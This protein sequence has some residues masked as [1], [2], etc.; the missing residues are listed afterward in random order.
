MALLALWVGLGMV[1][2]LLTSEA[3]SWPR[4]MLASPAAL[5]FPGIA[6]SALLQH[7]RQCKV[8]LCVDL[9]LCKAGRV[10]LVALLAISKGFV[11]VLPII[12]VAVGAGANKVLTSRVGRRCRGELERRS[13]YRDHAAERDDWGED[14]E[15]A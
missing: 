7:L 8:R 10:S 14:D 13:S 11:R 6:V 5:A 12:G 9:G 15:E 1:P 2:S 4:T 3:P